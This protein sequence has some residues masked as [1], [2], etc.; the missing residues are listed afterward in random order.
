MSCFQGDHSQWRTCLCVFSFIHPKPVKTKQNHWCILAEC[1]FFSVGWRCVTNSCPFG[2]TWFKTVLL[3]TGNSFDLTC[4]QHDCSQ[5][6][7]CSISHAAYMCFLKM[8][9]VHQLFINTCAMRRGRDS[10]ALTCAHFQSGFAKQKDGKGSISTD[11]EGVRCCPR[12]GKNT[13]RP[14]HTIFQ[15][16]SESDRNRALPL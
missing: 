13:S 16:I 6:I 14:S 4:V 1:V 7:I 11:R 3:T 10:H 15:I 9:S 5:E 12:G 2:N 8:W